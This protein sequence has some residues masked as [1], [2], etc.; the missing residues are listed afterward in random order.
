MKHINWFNVSRT[1]PK[2]QETNYL[3]L[4]TCNIHTC[5]VQIRLDVNYPRALN[6]V[7]LKLIIEENWAAIKNREASFTRKVTHKRMQPTSFLFKVIFTPR[8]EL[9]MFAVVALV[10]CCSF[11]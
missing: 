7:C 6:Y 9:A 10:N 3:F 4:L 8:V 5:H 1:P 11:Y 2:K